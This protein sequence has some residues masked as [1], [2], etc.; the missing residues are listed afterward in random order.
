M[1]EDMNGTRS[2]KQ[3]KTQSRGASRR[4]RQ[5]RAWQKG[6]P[7]TRGAGQKLKISKSLLHHCHL[8]S[9]AAKPHKH[10]K[11]KASKRPRQER[12]APKKKPNSR[13]PSPEAKRNE[14]GAETAALREGGAPREA[15][16]ARPEAEEEPATRTRRRQAPAAE[17]PRREERSPQDGRGHT[18][19]SAGG[20]TKPQGKAP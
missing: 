1:S 2:P 5:Y 20:P 19:K 18:T 12:H 13:P 14:G 15:G 11:P 8:F 17:P 9:D 4:G 7:A 6:R 3:Q 10:N 16:S